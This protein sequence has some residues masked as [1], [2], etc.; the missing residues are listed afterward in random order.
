MYQKV[1]YAILEK[2][3]GKK[4]KAGSQIFVSYAGFLENGTLFDT[5]SAEIA[6]AFGKLDPQ[7]ASQ[8]GYSPLPFQYGS[9]GAAIPGFEEGLS[10]LNIG[11]K[12]I[13]FIPSNLGYGEN[14]AGDVIP[15]NANIIFE[16]EILEKL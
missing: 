13:L 3:T 10:Q 8:N 5:S 1:Q 6:N 4:P 14:G 12:A 7:R 9:K 15:P 16:V 11:D 2:G